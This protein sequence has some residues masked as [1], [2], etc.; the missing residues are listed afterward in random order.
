MIA[1]VTT[2]TAEWFNCMSDYSK[3]PDEQ[4]CTSIELANLQ[5]GS[6][7]VTLNPGMNKVANTPTN[8]YLPKTDTMA[9]WG[10]NKVPGMAKAP[11]F[12]YYL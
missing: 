8:T 11:E 7:Y 5:W 6:S 1:N 9:D 2:G 12:S 4:N 10:P 3:P